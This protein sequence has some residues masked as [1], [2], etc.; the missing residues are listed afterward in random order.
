MTHAETEQRARILHQEHPE[1]DVH[2]FIPRQSPDGSWHVAKVPV[3]EHL[4]RPSLTPTIEA[5][6]KP[7]QTDDPRTGHEQRAPGIPGGL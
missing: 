3:P 4:R 7:P 2:R 6:P 1:R 5:R